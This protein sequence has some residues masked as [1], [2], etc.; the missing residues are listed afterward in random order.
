MSRVPKPEWVAGLRELC[1]SNADLFYNEQVGRWCFMIPGADGVPRGQFWGWFDQPQ[2]PATGLH[3]FRD[4]D[5]D[6][7][8]I[9]LHNLT[10]SFVG[11][12]KQEIKRRMEHNATLL[13]RLRRERA[14]LFA[15]MVHDR[16][17]QIFEI[18]Q[19]GWTR[20]VEDAHH[21][22]KEVSHAG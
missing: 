21:K 6:A 22:P 3:P 2:D 17:N 10:V 7:M 11:S 14:E 4:L 15:E 18:P 16:R 13:S 9:A 5:D 19:I 20:T 12:P 8:R 1:G